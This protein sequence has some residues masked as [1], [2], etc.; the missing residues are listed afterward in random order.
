MPRPV[1]ERN[2]GWLGHRTAYDEPL[3]TSLRGL[4]VHLLVMTGPTE[5]HENAQTV[6]VG[7]PDGP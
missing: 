2:L 4:M 5:V 6:P 3:G 7:I 1:Q